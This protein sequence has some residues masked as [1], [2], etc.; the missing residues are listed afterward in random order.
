MIDARSKP[1]QNSIAEYNSLSL[2]EWVITL[3]RMIKSKRLLDPYEHI[4][5]L[6]KGFLMAGVEF[7][8]PGYTE[9]AVEEIIRTNSGFHLKANLLGYKPTKVPPQI[10]RIPSNLKSLEQVADWMHHNF[11]PNARDTLATIAY[12]DTRVMLNTSHMCGDGV[13]HAKLVEHLCNPEEKWP[14]AVLPASSANDFYPLIHDKKWDKEKPLT[15]TIEPNISRI[16]K[17]RP[18]STK[19]DAKYIPASVRIPLSELSCYDPSTNK[20]HGIS[21]SQ[22]IAN[23]IS[24]AVFNGS[25]EPF[26][27]SVVYD[28]RR[29]LPPE[30]INDPSIQSYISSVT[31]SASPRLDMTLEELSK[32]MRAKFNESIENHNY[33]GHMKSVWEAVWRPWRCK[34][35]PGIGMEVSSIGQIK[36]HRPVK[37]AWIVLY[38]PDNYEISGTSFLTYSLISEE[39][40]E[41]LGT[42][43]FNTLELNEDD[44]MM[45]TKSSEFA[46]KNLKGNM[47]V[48]EALDLVGEQQKNYRK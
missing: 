13:H 35:V 12:D 6:W 42:M 7:E 1:G 31:V 38:S 45:L 17:K 30:K 14:D 4:F 32:Q 29:I 18:V 22:W 20:C 33:F 19:K 44:G 8:K 9:Q 36:I 16:L 28:L 11:T 21:E 34:S 43:Q 39:K 27:V 23:S 46:M 3:F 2:F 48:K 10:R 15:C 24:C 5:H 26:G 40:K 41:F 25:L 47:T 37:N